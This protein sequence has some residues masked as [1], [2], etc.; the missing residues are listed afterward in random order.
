MGIIRI[1]GP[2]STEIAEK[3]TQ[4]QTKNRE[5]IYVKFVDK[6][7]ETIDEGILLFFKNP[8]SFTGEDVVE[9][10]SHGSP[11]VL[12]QLLKLTVDCGARL[13]KPGE[14]SERAFLNGKIDLTQAEAIA[15]LI[16]ASSNKAAKLATRSLSGEFSS[17]INHIKDQVIYLRTFIEASID[18]SEEEID[19]LS[20]QKIKEK[21][22]FLLSDL[23]TILVQAEQSIIYQEGM[24]VV[25][26]GEPNVGKSSLLNRLSG[27]DKAI[28][29]EKAGTTRDVITAEINCDGIPLHIIDTAGLRESD[30][31]I[32]QEGIR[33][34]ILEI[35]KADKMLFLIE[36]GQTAEKEIE[37]LLKPLKKIPP[38]FVIKNKIDQTNEPAKVTKENGI[39]TIYLSAKTGE[40]V[41]SLKQQLKI[42]AGLDE[43]T[44]CHF[45]ARRRHL[46]ALNQA[47]TYLYE[48]K[49]QFKHRVIEL[50][51]ENLRLAQEAISQIT[52]EFTT[53]DLLGQIFSTFCVGK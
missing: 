22:D 15:D 11:V 45:L 23:E 51:A 9:L 24:R 8:H 2:L 28:V 12:D 53:E 34:A 5:A 36:N 49:L 32:E 37:K 17:R 33:R 19:T 25:I 21:I 52:G 39:T 1:S 48:A 6:K 43:H 3:I 18:F 29:T 42:E 27:E 31:V 38:Y 50:L 44:E 7:K 40:G 4:K 46:E 13:A 20:N 47:K 30:D 35:E 41:D 26:A 16:Q 14:F 10:Q